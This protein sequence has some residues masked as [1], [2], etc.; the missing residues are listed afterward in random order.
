MEHFHETKKESVFYKIGKGTFNLDDLLN[1]VF[2]SKSQSRLMKYW[3]LTFG[4]GKSDDGNL[5]RPIFTNKK[6]SSKNTLTLTEDNSG[7]TYRIADCCS[8]I[9]GDDILGFLEY[10]LFFAARFSPVSWLE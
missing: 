2:K 8:P 1:S 3:K 10:T 9:P 4:G 6:V 5:N 7:V